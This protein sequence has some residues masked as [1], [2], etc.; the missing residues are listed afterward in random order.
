MSYVRTVTKRGHKYRQLVESYWDKKAKRS[1]TRVLR[2]LGPVSPVYARAAL[3]T[4]VPV[5]S[6]T[7]GLLTTRMMMGSLTAAQVIE[8]VQAMGEGIP[9]GLLTAVGIRYDLGEKTLSLLLWLEP[10]LPHRAPAPSAAPPSRSR[11]DMPP[12][13]SHSKG[14]RT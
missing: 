12:P 13:S 14:R 9:P 8:T 6:P 2:H 7:F 3:P 5:D 1:R 4:T 11:D 10:S